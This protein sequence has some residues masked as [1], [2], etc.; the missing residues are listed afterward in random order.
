MN[1]L[2]ISFCTTG[3]AVLLVMISGYA[4][5]QGCNNTDPGNT[6]GNT[7]CVSFVYRG[8]G[9][10][11][12]TVRSADGKVWLQQNLGSSTV[13]SSL[14]DTGAYGDLFQWGRWDDGH[15]LRNSA[16]QANAPTP[17]NPSG[18]SGNSTG[19]YSAGYNSPSNWW[20][21]GAPD[22]QWT[23][24]SSSAITAVNGADPCK[25]IGAGWKL[26]TVNEIEA[27][28]TAENISDTS[29]ALASNLKL[30]P[31]GMKDY[32]GIFSPGTRLYL[33]S[34][35]SSPYT[36]SGQHLY[37]SQY[38]ALT[39]SGGRD[40]GMSV[41]CIKDASSML[42]TSDLG[43]SYAGVYPN[44]TEGIV[45]I[46]A[47]APVDHVMILNVAGQKLKADFSGN[48]IDLQQF[49][50]GLYFLEIHLKNGK[51]LSQKILKK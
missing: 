10:T 4:D 28:L 21:A 13:A 38:S 14:T 37:I 16:L 40:G 39:N 2:F 36:G 24:S 51:T 29:S 23:A 15:Q 17:N 49:P 32:N 34:S 3:L 33:W 46:K 35:S 44:P 9:V 18:L 47:E 50:K 31:A 1:K 26:P 42:G 43:K 27:L 30:V 7:G 8:Q 6:P 11:Y 5:A 20:S 41:R 22:N 25:A 12:S 19:F 48:R 45:N